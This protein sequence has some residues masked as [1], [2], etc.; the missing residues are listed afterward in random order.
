MEQEV[1]VRLQF[2]KQLEPP[3]SELNFSLVGMCMY[4]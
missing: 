2:H 3:I 1:G 4:M